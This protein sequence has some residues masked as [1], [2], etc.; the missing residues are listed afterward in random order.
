MNNKERNNIYN[1]TATTSIIIT[2]SIITILFAVA[3][4]NSMQE[5]K[6]LVNLAQG[7]I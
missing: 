1:S 3:C 7:N 5:T 6:E 4:F 2:L